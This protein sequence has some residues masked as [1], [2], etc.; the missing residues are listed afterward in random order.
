MPPTQPDRP[1]PVD[2]VLRDLMTALDRAVAT[3]LASAIVNSSGP[4]QAIEVEQQVLRSM[5][6]PYR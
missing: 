4:A 6:P 1:V 2:I 3:S 5:S